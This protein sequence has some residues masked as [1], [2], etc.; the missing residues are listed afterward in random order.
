MR[1]VK[2]NKKMMYYTVYGI[3]AVVMKVGAEGVGEEKFNTLQIFFIIFP[4]L[5]SAYYPILNIHA[6]NFSS[7]PSHLD[8]FQSKFTLTDSRA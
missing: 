2:Y 8:W 7:F 4:T 6:S 3:F 5:I 1:I